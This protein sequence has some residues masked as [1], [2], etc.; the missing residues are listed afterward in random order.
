VLPLAALVWAAA[1]KD[2]GFTPQSLLEL[3]KRRGRYRPA[4]FERLQLTR[5]FDLVEAKTTW[6]AALADAETFVRARPSEELGCLYYS[7]ARQ[8]F[9]M[10]APDEDVA[11][12]S[13]AVHFGAPGGVIP[14]IAGV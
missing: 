1:A 10:P 8:R 4:D 11:A 5:P 9:V 7:A 6:L 3:L 2:P 14:R 13:L 12:A